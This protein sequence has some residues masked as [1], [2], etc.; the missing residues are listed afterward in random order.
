MCVESVPLCCCVKV[1]QNESMKVEGTRLRV[2]ECMSVALLLKG[3]L[4]R[5]LKVKKMS[6]E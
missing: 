2:C 6:V 1:E 4:L 5:V 3:G